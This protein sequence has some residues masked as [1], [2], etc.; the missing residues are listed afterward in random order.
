MTLD[1]KLIIYTGHN[2]L[3]WASSCRRTALRCT[4]PQICDRYNTIYYICHIILYSLC[5]GVIPGQSTE[6]LRTQLKNIFFHEK[7]Q[8]CTI[9]RYLNLFSL[10]R[11]HLEDKVMKINKNTAFKKKLIW[12]GKQMKKK[13]KLGSPHKFFLFL[14]QWWCHPHRSRDSVSSVCGIFQ[15]QLNMVKNSQKIKYFFGLLVPVI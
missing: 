14:L 9:L 11:P 12:T 15:Q 8:I 10:N 4:T 3:L 2:S 7:F 13:Y 5:K 6:V 1:T